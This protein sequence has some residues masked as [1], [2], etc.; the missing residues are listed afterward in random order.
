MADI[1]TLEK[2]H[3]F[4]NDHVPPLDIVK[5]DARYSQAHKDKRKALLEKLRKAQEK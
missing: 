2:K 1:T 5:T 3:A 4:E